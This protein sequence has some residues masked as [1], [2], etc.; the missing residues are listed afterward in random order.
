MQ[1]RYQ[2]RFDGCGKFRFRPPVLFGYLLE[3]KIR[4]QDIVSTAPPDAERFPIDKVQNFSRAYLYW[5][6]AIARVFQVAEETY[7]EDSVPHLPKIFT[8]SVDPVGKTFIEG[9]D[10]QGEDIY[11]GI[12]FVSC[13]LAKLTKSTRDSKSKGNDTVRRESA[14]VYAQSVELPIFHIPADGAASTAEQDARQASSFKALMQSGGVLGVSAEELLRE[15]TSGQTVSHFDAA[16]SIDSLLHKTRRTVLRK[17]VDLLSPEKRR[18]LMASLAARPEAL[19]EDT[20]YQDTQFFAN[21]GSRMHKSHAITEARGLGEATIRNEEG[22]DGVISGEVEAD[23]LDAFLELQDRLNRN[24]A[25]PPSFDECEKDMAFEVMQD[26]DEIDDI[27]KHNFSVSYLGL[28]LKPWQ[29]QASCWIVRML[30]SEIGAAILGDYAGLGKTVSVLVALVELAARQHSNVEEWQEKYK[31]ILDPF[32]EPA[33]SSSTYVR[34]DTAAAPT[35]TGGDKTPPTAPLD[36]NGDTLMLSPPNDAE[37]IH[38][39]YHSISFPFL[40]ETRRNKKQNRKPT[41]HGRSALPLLFSFLFFPLFFSFHPP[42]F[43]SA[44]ALLLFY[45]TM[46]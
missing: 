46:Y 44:S 30:E 28:R 27:S 31:E 36:P 25:S 9:L 19:C 42:P 7:A 13:V 16:Q 23:A 8:G 20:A 6:R 45:E 11:R 34:N 5:L 4:K 29:P 43:L 39:K 22:K 2:L 15:F 12:V 40:S 32:R 37:I 33:A 17:D 14:R 35:T 18:S 3:D 1:D 38:S 24:S 21:A 26:L 10:W 41:A